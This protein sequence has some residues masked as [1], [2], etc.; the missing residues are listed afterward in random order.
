[1]HSIANDAFLHLFVSA[2]KDELI[3]SGTN[4][5]VS[6]SGLLL[7]NLLN[8]T[9]DRHRLADRRQAHGGQKYDQLHHA[10]PPR[11]AL[12]MRVKTTPRGFEP[13][14]PG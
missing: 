2:N 6:E 9:L 1:M 8:P 11:A 13:L 12:P 10:S 4:P 5:D 7:V 14:F 3:T